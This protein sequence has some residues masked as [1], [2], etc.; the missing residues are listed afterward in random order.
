[1][2]STVVVLALMLAIVPTAPGSQ[3]WHPRNVSRELLNQT[4]ELSDG[5]FN[6]SLEANLLR[7]LFQN[8]EHFL[9]LFL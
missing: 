6:H 9:W 4:E 5:H 3:L 8:G 2:K 7:E 1:M